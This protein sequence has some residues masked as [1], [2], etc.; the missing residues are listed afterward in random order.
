MNNQQLLYMLRS[1]R[2]ELDIQLAQDPDN[3]DLLDSWLAVINQI[4]NLE[5]LLAGPETV[6]TRNQMPPG[7]PD[8]Q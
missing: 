5:Q 4:Q 8:V 6:P 2:D 3:P 7:A 1:H